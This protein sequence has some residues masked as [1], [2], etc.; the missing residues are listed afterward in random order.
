MKSTDPNSKGDAVYVG[1][2]DQTGANVYPDND[3]AATVDGFVDLENISIDKNG[4]ITGTNKD[5]GDPVVVGY[6]ALG[7]VENL[8]GVLHT[9]GPYYTAGKPAGDIRWVPLETPSPET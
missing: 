4:K 3:P 9:E 5:T 1:V 7:S 8:N 2:D 6:I